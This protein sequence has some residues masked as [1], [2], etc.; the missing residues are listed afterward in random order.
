MALLNPSTLAKLVGN[1]FYHKRSSQK[2][3]SQLL[4]IAEADGVVVKEEDQLLELLAKK[5]QVSSKVLAKIKN[6]ELDFEDVGPPSQAKVRFQHLY[7][8][9][10][11]MII[12]Q[13]VAF[14]E[15]AICRGF[16]VYLGYDEARTEELID[17][18]IANINNGNSPED[19]RARVERLINI[20]S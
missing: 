3:L 17:A 10:E 20:K 6:H 7:E 16:A 18:I 2:H 11:M 4:A 13:K 9:V 1:L 5:H 15:A 8:M 14:E 12:D 19:T